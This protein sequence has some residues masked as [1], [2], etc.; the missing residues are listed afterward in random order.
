MTEQT[1]TDDACRRAIIDAAKGKHHR[2]SVKRILQNIDIHAI[3]LKN[4]VL[5]G[6]YQPKPYK[7]CHVVDRPSKK[8]RILEKPVFFPD[9]CVHHLAINL[10]KGRILK[11]LDP[12]CI[13]G[14]EGKGIHYGHNTIKRWLRDDVKHTKYCLKGDVRKCYDSIKPKTIMITM[15]KFI[16]DNRYLSL[17]QKIAY[18]HPSLPLGNYTS[19][20]F[21]NLILSEL[22]K[23]ARSSPGCSHYLRYVDDFIVLGSNK[24]KLHR[25]VLSII[26]T[27][28]TLGLDLKDNWQI[29]PVRVRGIDMLGYRYFGRY[30]LMRKRNV[31]AIMRAI[32]KYR[33]NPTP[34]K[35]RSLLSR[36]GQIKHFNNYHFSQKYVKGIG[37]QR[38]KEMAI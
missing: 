3:F 17:I 20:W 10:I 9:Q 6:T 18:S 23:T 21:A 12:Y 16:K 24:R 26:R 19:G 25:L 37:I 22:D 33:K 34:R 38:I 30:T 1:V 28:R 35:A 36:L 2:K 31:L 32:R 5:D 8:A 27:L 14:I 29:F 7:E 11:R 4:M 13:G 15:R